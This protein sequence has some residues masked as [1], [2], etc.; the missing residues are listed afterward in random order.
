MDSVLNGLHANSVDFTHCDFKDDTFR[1]TSFI[2]SAFGSSTFAYNVVVN[3]IF[4]ACSFPDTDI[5][6]CHFDETSFDGCDL[7]H[8]LIKNCT[9]TRCTFRNCQTNNQLFEGCRM[10][11][12]SFEHTELQIQTITQNFGLV[13]SQYTGVL[14]TDRTDV[15]HGTI[16]VG[17]LRDCLHDTSLP[18]LHRLNIEYFL[19]G[20]LLDGST[21][22]DETLGLEAWL[23]MFRHATS[24]AV[25]LDQWVDFLLYLYNHD[26]LTTHT[27]IAVHGMTSSLLDHIRSENAYHPAFATL[28]GTYLAAARA[29]DEYLDSLST[30]TQDHIPTLRMLVEGGSTEQYYYDALE[31]VFLRAPAQIVSLVPRNSPWE[32]LLNFASHDALL[33]FL[34]IFLATRTRIELLRAVPPAPLTHTE[35][36]HPAAP[37][38]RRRRD[39]M[40]NEP[41][42][43][44]EFGGIRP[45]HSS[46]NL[47]LKAYL[48]G[49][50]VAEFRLDIASG[51]LSRIRKTLKSIL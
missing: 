15:P 41:V 17:K 5:Q 31:P 35:N 10:T 36:N 9:F 16:G 21:L 42:L 44:V 3:C 4:R 26:Q 39:S 18:P 25:T 1:S 37:R 6:H 29:V 19:G 2:S 20:S 51:Q 33:C 14:R 12:C 46:P 22:L 13:S 45:S 48:P 23:P 11:E 50:L 24:F 30:L 34:A 27:L 7:R 40:P 38:P 8:L 49:N 28:S 32:L 47:R 43:S